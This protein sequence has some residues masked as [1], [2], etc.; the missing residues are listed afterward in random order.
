MSELE[1]HAHYMGIASD[2]TRAVLL[3]YTAPRWTDTERQEWKSI[4][5]SDEATTKVLCDTMRALEKQGQNLDV[6][7]ARLAAREEKPDA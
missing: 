4:T 7:T 2:A 3:F 5:G 6:L 1:K